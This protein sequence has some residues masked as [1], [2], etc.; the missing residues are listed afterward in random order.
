MGQF[1]QITN[2]DK[3]LA[4]A[5]PEILANSGAVYMVLGTRDT[6]QDNFTARLYEKKL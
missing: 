5:Q 6:P 1:L 2:F 3:S 4:W